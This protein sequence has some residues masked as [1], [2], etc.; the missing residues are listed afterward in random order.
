MKNRVRR[1]YELESLFLGRPVRPF[2]LAVTI[3]TGVIAWTLLTDGKMDWVYHSAAHLI[4]LTAAVS[5]IFLTIGWW[6]RKEWF[7]EWG[8]LLATGVWA[9]RAVYAAFAGQ[10][11][12]VINQ[13]ASMLLSIA[14]AIGAGGAYLLER[15]D[16]EMSNGV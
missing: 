2:H 15:Y 1:G 11:L 8:L 16:D 12:L 4:G 6:F 9:S 13:W 5:S 3:A 7:A 10:G 14:W